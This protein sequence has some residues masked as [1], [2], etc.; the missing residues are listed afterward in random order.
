MDALWRAPY[1]SGMNSIPS[2]LPFGELSCRVQTKAREFLHAN[3]KTSCPAEAASASRSIAP[4]DARQA[5]EQAEDEEKEA[6]KL[7]RSVSRRNDSPL[8]RDLCSL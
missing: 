3:R 6:V 2:S 8:S 5:G 4:G 1:L 7:S